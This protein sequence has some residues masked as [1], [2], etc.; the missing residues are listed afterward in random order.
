MNICSD[1]MAMPLRRYGNDE[2]GKIEQYIDE[3]KV[4]V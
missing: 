3:M 1:Y 2:R 4:I